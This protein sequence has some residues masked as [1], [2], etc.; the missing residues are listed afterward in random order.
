MCR[1]FI[2]VLTAS[3]PLEDCS[4]KMWKMH[5]LKYFEQVEATVEWTKSNLGRSKIISGGE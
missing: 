3:L 2:E 1:M 4:G 5:N